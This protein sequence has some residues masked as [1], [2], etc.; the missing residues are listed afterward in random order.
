M[1][2]NDYT[3]SAPVRK[4]LDKLGFTTPTEIQ[5]RAFE[6]LLGQEQTDFHGQAQTG[7]GKTLAF[8]IPLIEKIDITK[9][10][11]QALIVAPTREL[12]LQICESLQSVAVFSGISIESIYGGMPIEPQVRSLKRGVQIVVGTPGRLNDHLRRGTFGLKDLSVLVLDEADIML[13][14]G[15]KEDIDEILSFAPK[16]RQIWLFSATVKGGI[17]DI[18]N[19]HMSNPVTVS[20]SGNSVTGA[21]TEQF[22]CA[23]PRKFKLDA[24]RRFLDMADDFYGVVFCQTKIMASEV[25][26]KLGKAGY[27]VGALHGDMS[28]AMRNAVIKDFRNSKYKVLV[29]TDVAARGIDVNDLTHVVN[30]SF[31][32]DEDSYVHRIGRT[33]RAG[34]K[35]V[36]IT[37]VERG[38]LERV[39]RLARR[40]KVDINPI[41]IPSMDD[42]MNMRMDQFV[43]TIDKLCTT[44]IGQ[45]APA[46]RLYDILMAHP[47]EEL[48][49]GMYNMLCQTI[50]KG[51]EESSNVEFAANSSYE[52]QGGGTGDQENIQELAISLG[53]DDGINKGDVL[54]YLLD[55]RVI[56]AKEINKIR[57][58][59]RRTFVIVP[60]PLAA[61]LLEAL[62]GRSIAGKKARIMY[63][64]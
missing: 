18:K 50:L 26:A 17:Q 3:L 64:Q 46:R 9:K 55:S 11:T 43:G 27:A 63:A 31:P 56:K 39:K 8:G 40:F 49:N 32:E 14:M 4:A 62:R 59:Q 20:V 33:G 38:Q 42:I 52:Q 15:F 34:K 36:A 1:T 58:I 24:L 28:Q 5:Q 23:V 54:N 12:V 6:L 60:A 48:A 19:S 7:T 37:F 10:S 53:Q 29:A 21:T 25:A 16:R 22:Y 2:F 44:K 45:S 35:G 30:Y 13:D 51:Y 47:Q 57:V 61:Q 41:N